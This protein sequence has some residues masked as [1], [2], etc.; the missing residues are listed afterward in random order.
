MR[1]LIVGIMET[2]ED[3]SSSRSS[4]ASLSIGKELDIEDDREDDSQR[5][6][7]RTFIVGREFHSFD[8]LSSDVK[9]YECVNSV[10]LYTRSSRSIEAAKKRAPKRHFLEGHV[11]SEI[12]YGCTTYMAA[13]TISRIQRGFGNHKG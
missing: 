10:T 12:D 13:A 2:G 6:S 7:T 5:P 8:E 1:V 4:S 9:E 11:Y 3:D